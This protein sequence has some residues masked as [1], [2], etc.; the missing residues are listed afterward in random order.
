MRGFKMQIR[1]YIGDT[2]ATG[3]VYHP[4]YLNFAERARTEMC[5]SLDP[6]LLTGAMDRGFFFVLR[7]A[8]LDFISPA[9]FDDIIEVDV[10]VPKIGNTS[11]QILHKITSA[12]NGAKICDV[13]CTLVLVSHTG[14][15]ITPTS[16][17]Q[18]IKDMLSKYLIT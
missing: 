10:S 6:N 14:H 18:N 5:R 17:P 4:N 16:I 13:L 11:V 15:K 2:D 12:K 7:S 8:S 1:V 3:V 9:R